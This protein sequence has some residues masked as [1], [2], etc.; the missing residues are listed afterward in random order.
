MTQ[1][2]RSTRPSVFFVLI[3]PAAAVPRPTPAGG[4]RSAPKRLSAPL[5]AAALLAGALLGGGV[6][7]QEATVKTDGQ[8]RSA[9]SLGASLSDGNSRASSLAL[10][11]EAVQATT[12]W[13]TTLRGSALYT[14]T[15]G[16]TTGE[17]IRLGARHDRNFN[18]HWF[19]FGGLDLDRDKFANLS[20][21][22]QATAGLG[23]HLLRTDTTT[24]DLFAG[25][26]LN[27]DRFIAPALVDGQVRSRYRYTSVLL[28]Q[29]SQHR[30]TE[31]TGAKQR[32]AVFPN[33]NNRGEYRAIWDAS[34]S[35][36]MSA[37]LSLNVG[38]GVTHNSEPGPGRQR[39]D[40][41]LTTGVA[42]R[43]E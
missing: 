29:E 3:R 5:G 38:L 7:A 15:D 6:H 14:S 20:L 32:L 43:F 17:R 25:L 31:S 19:G 28:A 26:G 16:N 21:R 37:T 27:E 2:R 41:L 34:L 24:W 18:A 33:L 9:F 42:V 12:T 10:G 39:T 40:T 36:A 23:R 22:S 8:L 1:P 30:F 13:K 11:G 4:C 35:V